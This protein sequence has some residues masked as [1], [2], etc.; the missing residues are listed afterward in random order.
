M[1]FFLSLLLLTAASGGCTDNKSSLLGR[2]LS[3]LLGNFDGGM[4][5]VEYGG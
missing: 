3:S 5:E 1:H 4:S 2:D